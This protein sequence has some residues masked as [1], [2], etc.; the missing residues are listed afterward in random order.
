MVMSVDDTSGFPDRLETIVPT[1][2][3]TGSLLG[4]RIR[5]GNQSGMTPYGL[6]PIGEV[7]DYLL[8]VGCPQN[9][10]L[11]IAIEIKKE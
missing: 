5:I 11:P 10:C 3:I 7:E 8:M 1:D 2:A 6:Q 4:V 9:V